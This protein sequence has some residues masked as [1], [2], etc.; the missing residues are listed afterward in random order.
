MSAALDPRPDEVAT[1]ALDP[2]ALAELREELGDH[3]FRSLL[4]TFATSADA[5]LRSLRE[6]AVD[7]SPAD[8]VNLVHLMK[9]LFAQY[10]AL[11]AADQAQRVL[12]AGGEGGSGAVWDL[13]ESGA[14]A[15]AE[16]RAVL[17][18]TQ[19]VSAG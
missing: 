5:R 18:T 13:I 9:G 2:G 16:A 4:R 6:L 11:A 1:A 3:V 14:A 15:V 12:A 17:A 7:G 8:V 19:Q 10:G